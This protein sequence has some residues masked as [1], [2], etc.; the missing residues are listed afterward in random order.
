VFYTGYRFESAPSSEA[1]GACF[2]SVTGNLVEV[3]TAVRFEIFNGVI[4]FSVTFL[5]K[6][7]NSTPEACG[8]TSLRNLQECKNET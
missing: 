8:S 3:S 1:E 5:L 7:I 4:H 2:K 6:E